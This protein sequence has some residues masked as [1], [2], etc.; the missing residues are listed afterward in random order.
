MAEHPQL[1]P[2]LAPMERAGKGAILLRDRLLTL[3]T[4]SGVGVGDLARLKDWMQRP[5][6]ALLASLSPATAS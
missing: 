6:A 3:P 1:R 2:I 4:H 5:N